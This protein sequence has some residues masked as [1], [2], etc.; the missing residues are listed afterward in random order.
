M[1]HAPSVQYPVGRSFLGYGVLLLGLAV[2]GL[3]LLGL[4]MGRYGLSGWR[5]VIGCAIWAVWT[6]VALASWRRAPVGHLQWDAQ[7]PNPHASD[8]V[9]TPGVW[10]WRSSGY[11]QGV[12]LTHVQVR[13]DG[14]ERLLLRLSRSAG[15]GW[16][17]WAER[18]ADAARWEAF[19]RALIA[20]QR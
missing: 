10:V 16:W 5:A 12:P 3:L 8:G 9:S 19:R 18:G 2:L 6:V 20:A 14:Q 15:L 13:W 11:P 4:G 1:R 7:A 17:V